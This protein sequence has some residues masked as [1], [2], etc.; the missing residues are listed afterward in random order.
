MMAGGILC[1]RGDTS[2]FSLV[3]SMQ[4]NRRLIS[5]SA[6]ISRTLA[7]FISEGKKGGRFRSSERDS[8]IQVALKLNNFGFS[9]PQSRSQAH[10]GR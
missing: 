5:C 10:T 8:D 2:E 9:A 6:S 4:V 1:R 7:C 3:T